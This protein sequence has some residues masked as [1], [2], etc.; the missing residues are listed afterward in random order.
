MVL[1]SL[2]TP[3]MKKA[4]R[5]PTR[6][7]LKHNPDIKA[8]KDINVKNR[9]NTIITE[10]L[11]NEEVMITPEGISDKIVKCLTTASETAIPRKKKSGKRTMN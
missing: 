7:P 3:T 1:T 6:A 2:T 4:R 10:H 8:L 5:K 9:Y 11:L